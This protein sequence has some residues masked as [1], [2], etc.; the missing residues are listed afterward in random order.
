MKT[1][2]ILIID[3][4]KMVR[5][6]IRSMLET[7]D[8]K[9]QFIVTEAETGEE[10]VESAITQ[11][12]D[13]ILMDY[14]LPKIDGA[15]AVKAIIEK[16]PEAK[17]L[18]LSSYNEF[19]YVN[20][21]M[22]MGARGYILKNVG[23]DEMIR[24]IETI[25][26]GKKYYSNDVAVKLMTFENNNPVEIKARKGVKTEERLTIRELE[27]LKCVV[28]GLTSEE[29]AGKLELSKRTVDK[30]R[31]NIIDKLGVKNRSELIKFGMELFKPNG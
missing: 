11:E 17:I 15:D 7:Y 21:M 14:Q 3:D 1:V 6:G 8:D 26:D 29:I 19:M 28:D 22:K 2:R 24:A 25:L 5:D 12:H 9:Y 31:Q 4:H 23:P 13:I 20:R 10:G 27:I 18:A 16:K 30:H